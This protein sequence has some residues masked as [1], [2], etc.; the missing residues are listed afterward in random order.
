[1]LPLPKSSSS[2]WLEPVSIAHL[3]IDFI[4]DSA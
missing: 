4:A 3:G 1:L 2:A